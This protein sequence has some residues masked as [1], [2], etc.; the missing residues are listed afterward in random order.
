VKERGFD[1]VPVNVVD[2][3]ASDAFEQIYGAVDDDW[4]FAEC[5]EKFS[6]LMCWVGCYLESK[7]YTSSEASRVEMAG[8]KTVDCPIVM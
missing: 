5:L 8:A 2:I 4:C 3:A 1:V 6:A 7:W